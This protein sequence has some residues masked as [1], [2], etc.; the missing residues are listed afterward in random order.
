MDQLHYITNNG[1][2]EEEEIDKNNTEETCYSNNNPTATEW[3][4]CKTTNRKLKLQHS[5]FSIRIWPD[6]KVETGNEC[7]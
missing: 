3:S 1:I 4:K 5:A 7:E 6:W 2:K